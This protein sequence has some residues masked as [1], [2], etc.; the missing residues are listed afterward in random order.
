MG[1]QARRR[2]QQGRRPDTHDP[3]REPSRGRRPQPDAQVPRPNRLRADH[4]G[5]EFETW[6]NKVWTLGNAV[7]NEISLQQFR[8]NITITLLNE[9]GQPAVAYNVMRCWVSEFTAMADLDSSGNAVLI[10]SLTLQH[11]GWQRDPGVA[12]PTEPSF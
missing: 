9:A 1:W 4:V 11:E 12:E 2:H 6:A 3:G 5:A 7:G 10:Q 8:K